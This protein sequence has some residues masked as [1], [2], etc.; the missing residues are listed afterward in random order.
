MQICE[1]CRELH[2]LTESQRVC[3]LSNDKMRRLVDLQKH[4]DTAKH[5]ANQYQQCKQDLKSGKVHSIILSLWL[6]AIYGIYTKLF[7]QCG[8][9]CIVVQDFTKFYTRSGKVVDLVLVVFFRNNENEIN[10]EYLDYFS[11]DPEDFYLVRAAWT[12]LLIETTKLQRFNTIFIWS[13]GAVQHFKQAKTLYWFSTFP[14]VYQKG[15]NYS[16][17]ASYHG[18]SMCDSHAGI[19]KQQITRR[20]T[21]NQLQMLNADDICEVYSTLK[22]TTTY[23]VIGNRDHVVH[24]KPFRGIL[25]YHQYVSVSAGVLGCRKLSNVGDF[26]YESMPLAEITTQ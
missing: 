4:K 5:Q 19:G 15:V 17:F 9:E 16:F 7:L 6:F 23:S 3:P 20:E 10:W 22:K 1:K 24:V 26:N 11:T 2:D 8:D 13:D 12:H 14:Q 25:S 21:E 18:H